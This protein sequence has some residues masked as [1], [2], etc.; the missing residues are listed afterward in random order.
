MSFSYGAGANPTIDYVR[1]LVAD[2]AAV[3]YIFEDSEIMAAYQIDAVAV[4]GQGNSTTFTSYGTASA[5]RAA[6]T[7]LDALAANKARLGNALKVLDIQIDTKSAAADLRAQA[8]LLREVE[9]ESG[10]FAIAEMINE[11]FGARERWWKQA[12]RQTV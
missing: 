10:T 3:G 7:L 9:M 11:P 6:A 4:I 1:L 5:R 12:M 2:T 8:R